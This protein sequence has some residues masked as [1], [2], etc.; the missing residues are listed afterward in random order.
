VVQFV[1]FMAAFRHPGTLDPA[2]AGVLGGF[3]AMWATFVPPFIWIFLGGPYVES[4]IGNASLNAALSA[5]TAAVVGIILNLAVW[6]GLHTLFA[7]TWDF[8][9]FGLSLAIP[10][11]M[12]LRW[13]ALVLSLASVLAIFR[14]KIGMLWVFAAS[15]I[16]GALYYVAMGAAA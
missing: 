4:L 9:G 2:L 13:P 6:F 8:H 3:L 15:A 16:A 11:A 5:I 1:G 10:D 12:S 7:A 14:F